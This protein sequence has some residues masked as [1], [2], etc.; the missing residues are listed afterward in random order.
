[1][2]LHSGIGLLRHHS[3]RDIRM[4]FLFGIGT[5]LFLLVFVLRW[6]PR[7]VGLSVWLGS[8]AVTGGAAMALLY[9]LAE[10]R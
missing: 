4:G 8:A 2:I 1:M 10:G 7:L 5:A 3:G 6:V 9:L